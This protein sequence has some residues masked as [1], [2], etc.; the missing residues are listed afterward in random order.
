MKA[1]RWKSKKA[2]VISVKRT[3]FVKIR[4]KGRVSVGRGFSLKRGDL[5][6]GECGWV[7][8]SV[9]SVVLRIEYVGVGEVEVNMDKILFPRCRPMSNFPLRV[10]SVC[11]VLDGSETV[12]G[13]TDLFESEENE[14][15]C[16]CQENGVQ[17]TRECV[18]VF[19]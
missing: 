18:W 2:V 5:G 11:R 16:Y 15:C 7:W 14:S 13:G 10:L 3:F 17:H 9:G 1:P 8:S 12:N 19:L 4:R 6:R